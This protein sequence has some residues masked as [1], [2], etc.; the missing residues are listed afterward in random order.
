MKEIDIH[1]VTGLLKLYL[2]ELPES[3]FT[4]AMYKKYFDAFNITNQSEKSKRLLALFSVLTQPNQNIIIVLIDHLNKVNQFEEHN[5]MSLHNLATVFG[6]TVLRPGTTATSGTN[7][8]ADSFT[9]GTIDV[10]AQAGI[11]YFFLRRK[12]SG[13][14]LINTNCET[15]C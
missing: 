8:I 1:A 2:R 15:S 3:L 9:L 11:L 6:P 13:L 7:S 4:N 12:A 10:M 5:K 14:S